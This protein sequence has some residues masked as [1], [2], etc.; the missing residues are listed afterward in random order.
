MAAYNALPAL[1]APRQLAPAQDGGVAAPR[2][3]QQQNACAHHEEGAARQP[4]DHTQPAHYLGKMDVK[5]EHCGALHWL[6]EHLSK[7]SKWSPKFGMCCF[8]GK[9]ELPK[10]ENPPPELLGFLTGTDDASKKFHDNIRRY[11]NALAMTS[12]GVQQDHAINQAGR[13]PWLF[14]IQGKLSHFAGSLL[15]AEGI[16][17]MYA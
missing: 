5:C 8:E 16:D 11:N 6:D 1:L 14:K 4:F 17:P 7:S 10:L 13:G 3:A 9:I 15:P 2:A 12:V